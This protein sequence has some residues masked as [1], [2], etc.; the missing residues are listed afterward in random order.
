MG[1]LIDSHMHFFPSVGSSYVDEVVEFL[2]AKGNRAIAVSID[3]KSSIETLRIGRS[4]PSQIIPFIGI[5]P[6]SSSMDEIS[7]F[8]YIVNNETGILGIGE[9][10][11]DGTYSTDLVTIEK[12]RVIFDQM[13]SIAETLNKPIS[14]H[15]RGAVTETLLAIKRFSLNRVMLHWF[16]GTESQLKEAQEMGYMVSFGPASVYSKKIQRLVKISN[17]EMTLVES[18]GPVKFS[19]CFEGHA[20]D[21]RMV[22]SVV[23]TLAWIWGMSYDEATALISKNTLRYLK[24]L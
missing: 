13:L 21:P 3:V 9:I 15:S 22:G 6:A 11:L 7:S 14:V 19:A 8:E 5:H 18:D 4:F 20:A 16:A 1:L 17:P 2:R 23:N 12:Q 24:T 10:G